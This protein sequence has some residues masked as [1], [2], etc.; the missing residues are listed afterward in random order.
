[1]GGRHRSRPWPV[2]PPSPFRLRSAS[3]GGQVGLRRTSRDGVARLLGTRMRGIADLMVRSARK[4]ASRTMGRLHRSRPW[5]AL[6]ATADQSRRRCTRLPG[7]R[8]RTSMAGF[9]VNNNESTSPCPRIGGRADTVRRFSKQKGPPWA[10]H[11]GFHSRRDGVRHL[12]PVPT[13]GAMGAGR[14]SN[15]GFSPIPFGRGRQKNGYQESC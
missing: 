14:K 9:V 4:R 3:Y 12:L 6:R 13:P 7:A 2:L 1:M 8:I 10:A 11:A 5:P 15:C